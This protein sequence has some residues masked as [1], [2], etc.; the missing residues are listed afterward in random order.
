MV[1]QVSRLTALSVRGA[2]RGGAPFC[3]NLDRVAL[4]REAV[5]GFI[6]CVQDFVR[7]P[8]FKQKHFFPIVA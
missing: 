8:L 5:G 1:F 4:S 3:I 2:S 7:D 6:T